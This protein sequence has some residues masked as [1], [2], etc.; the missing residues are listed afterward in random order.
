MAKKTQVGNPYTAHKKQKWAPR[1]K[2]V[3]KTASRADRQLFRYRDLLEDFYKLGDELVG[4]TGLVVL[5]GFNCAHSTDQFRPVHWEP[6]WRVRPSFVALSV[7]TGAAGELKLRLVTAESRYDAA[8][9][10]LKYTN[11]NGRDGLAYYTFT[12]EPRPG[13]GEDVLDSEGSHVLFT[14]ANNCLQA[15]I[16]SA[17][18]PVQSLVLPRLLCV[19]EGDRIPIDNKK[20]EAL[21]NSMPEAMRSDYRKARLREVT[22]VSCGTKFA[23]ATLLTDKEL[24]AAFAEKRAWED[25]SELLGADMPNPT[26]KLL[27]AANP[28]K[29]VI[30]GFLTFNGQPVEHF[31]ADGNT[32]EV[33]CFEHEAVTVSA[34]EWSEFS[35]VGLKAGWVA[36]APE[37]LWE[38]MLAEMRRHLPLPEMALDSDLLDAI[39]EPDQPI[40]FSKTFEQVL[41]NE[42][43]AVVRAMLGTFPLGASVRKYVQPHELLAA[44]KAPEE[45]MRV[46]AYAK[47]QVVATTDFN[48][49]P[50]HSTGSFWPTESEIIRHQAPVWSEE[51]DG[52]ELEPGD[53]AESEVPCAQAL[54]EQIAE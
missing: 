32:V 36:S 41:E 48:S 33:K 11:S 4:R 54:R 39:A 50:S 16:E 27:R 46:G 38:R 20:L 9:G 51:L 52:V 44:A 5:P 12:N 8:T 26:R 13:G 53:V 21:V 28:A 45:P 37:P 47:V 1:K 17:G 19:V 30:D 2:H 31:K 18:K 43:E 6:N 49:L 23:D 10:K 25:F 7:G 29:R 35:A 34:A 14:A 24:K 22:V 42:P 40:Q 3:P 15:L